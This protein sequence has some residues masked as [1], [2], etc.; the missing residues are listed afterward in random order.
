L[1]FMGQAVSVLIV[2]GRKSGAVAE[3]V[4]K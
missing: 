2:A 3:A 1:L 4:R